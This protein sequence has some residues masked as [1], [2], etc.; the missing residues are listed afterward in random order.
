[1]DK[2]DVLYVYKGIL[3]SQKKKEWNNVIC[4]NMDGCRDYHFKWS[5]SEK[6]KYHMI[7]FICGSKKVI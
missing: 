7:S 4:N 5:K 1:M 6:N 2:E 3:V